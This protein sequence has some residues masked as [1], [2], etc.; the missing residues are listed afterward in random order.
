M[1]ALCSLD[2]LK[3][4]A[5]GTQA[6]CEIV[7]LNEIGNRPTSLCTTQGGFCKYSTSHWNGELRR[8]HG[9]AYHSLGSIS[10][11]T[12]ALQNEESIANALHRCR[13]E[14]EHSDSYTRRQPHGNNLNFF[15]YFCCIEIPL[16][17]RIQRNVLAQ[18]GQQTTSSTR[19]WLW[20]SSTRQQTAIMLLWAVF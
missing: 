13:S 16:Y 7:T 6:L 20:T 15:G 17:T 18:I 10:T 5:F 4:L 8:M 2:M 14:V 19:L 11:S 12:R 3:E 9:H 1:A